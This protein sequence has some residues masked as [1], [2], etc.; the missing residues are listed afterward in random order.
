VTL[1]ARH[2]GDAAWVAAWDRVLDG[3][4]GF[5]PLALDPSTGA[6]DAV[7]TQTALSVLRK[8]FRNHVAYAAHR[9]G[10]VLAALYGAMG[11]GLPRDI[12]AVLEK[13]GEEVGDRLAHRAQLAL[14]VTA[15]HDAP[16]DNV[17][18][19]VA[20][21]RALARVVSAVPPAALQEEL[22]GG[23]L[24][25]AAARA[26]DAASPHVRRGA[27]GVLTEAALAAGEGALAAAAGG[28][29]TP[30]QLKLVAGYVE[31]ARAERGS[32]SGGGGGGGAA[33]RG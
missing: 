9:A 17:P 20:A 14:A 7:L 6:P 32:G 13:T 21:G 16:L 8:L 25:G 22:A 12:Q 5:V 33:A 24:V 10:A 3:V 31:R 4:L 26:L 2:A 27:V 23:W 29:L 11:P 15:Y 28:L 1:P 30:P 19:A 18:A